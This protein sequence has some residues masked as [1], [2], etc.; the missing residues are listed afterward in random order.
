MPKCPNGL[1]GLVFR[2]L[3]PNAEEAPQ[4]LQKGLQ[5]LGANITLATAVQQRDRAAVATLQEFFQQSGLAEARATDHDRA[6]RMGRSG[7]AEETQ[8]R[9]HDFVATDKGRQTATR[10]AFE[11]PGDRT[12]P[13]H[14]AKAWHAGPGA[15][16][17][18]IGTELEEIG[19]RPESIQA[20]ED[21]S[22]SG[23][24]RHMSGR[25]DHIA[26]QVEPAT[27]DVAFGKKQRSGMDARMHSQRHQCRRQAILTQLADRLL[28]IQ[29]GLGC[30]PTVILARSRIAEYGEDPVTLRPD[31]PPAVPSH[32]L[33]PRFRA[34]EPAVRKTAPTPFPGPTRWS[35]PSQRTGRSIGD[36]RRR[37][38]QQCRDCLR[39]S[40]LRRSERALAWQVR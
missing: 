13:Q 17:V 16:L 30:S 9:G 1:G 4:H 34:I 8:Q 5:D 32:R 21:L 19:M 24:L 37:R 36:V 23:L 28:N 3:G 35:P 11:A 6:A 22:G 27:L 29:G 33:V 18:Q 40:L 39:S 2:H 20:D 31:H 26:D 38:K 14:G 10:G 12:A 15:G 25:V 7:A